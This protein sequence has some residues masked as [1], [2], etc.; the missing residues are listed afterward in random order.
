METF[1]KFCQSHHAEEYVNSKMK[2]DYLEPGMQVPH[3]ILDDCKDSF[4]SVDEKHQKASIQLFIVTAL[5]ALLCH[6][7]QVLWLVNMTSAGENQHYVLAIIQHLLDHL[8]MMQP[9]VFFM[10]LGASF[11]KWG[12]LND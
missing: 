12:L 11:E 1:V 9:L 2:E 10:T 3:S 8:P 6:H 4:V 7:D 5:V